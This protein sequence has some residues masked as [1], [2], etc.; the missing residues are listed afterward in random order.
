MVKVKYRYRIFFSKIGKCR[1]IGHLD[2]QT[3]FQRAIKRAGLPAAYS[4][5]FN[6]HQLLSFAQPLSLGYGG[7]REI[8]ELEMTQTM[9][10]DEIVARLGA[11]MPAGINILDAVKID[12]PAKS[13]AALIYGAV[14]DVIF[15]VRIAPEILDAILEKKEI[16]A[17]TKGKKGLVE[18][19]SGITDLKIADTD[20]TTVRCVLSAG[21][22]KNLR[23]D[24]VAKLII[25]TGGFDID[26][27]NI[28]FSRREILLR[29]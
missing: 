14:Y 18:I 6:P 11:Q 16:F 29:G 13:A 19:R 25:E 2:L 1:F 15:P 9:P 23:A 5:G 17:E 7:L 3:F 12:L 24:T 22:A 8:V 4:E 28:G 27:K 10:T 21:S 26:I 20:T